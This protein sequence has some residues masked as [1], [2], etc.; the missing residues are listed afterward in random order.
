[1]MKTIYD[2]RNSFLTA[3]I[4]VAALSSTPALA[5]TP[6]SAP[7]DTGLHLGYER[8]TGKESYEAQALSADQPVIERLVA[9]YQGRVNSEMGYWFA[10]SRGGYRFDDQDFPG[11]QHLRHESRVNAGVSRNGSFPGGA[12]ALGVGYGVDFLQVQNSAR[13][14]DPEPAFFFS[15]WQVLHGVTLNESLRL[16]TDKISVVLDGRWEPYL[17]AHLADAGLSMPGYL[18]SVRLAPRLS[19]WDDRLSVGYAFERVLGA[20]FERHSEGPFLAISVRRF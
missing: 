17:F 11:T 9:S 4:G 10:L 6:V 20:G 19:I 13:L 14:S 1:M 15:P 2:A 18:T 7:A 5:F 8:A 3:L 16:G 12:W